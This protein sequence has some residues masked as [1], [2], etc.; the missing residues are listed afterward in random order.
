METVK[1]GQRWWREED[2]SVLTITRVNIEKENN[3]F[4]HWVRADGCAGLIP[5][6]DEGTMKPYPNK[7]TMVEIDQ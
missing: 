6:C 5:L 7:L 4:A 3:S 1:V 2:G